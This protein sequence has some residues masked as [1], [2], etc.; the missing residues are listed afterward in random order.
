MVGTF[1]A[2][3]LK[4]GLIIRVI[5]VDFQRGKAHDLRGESL[6][7]AL[8]ADI[9][10]NLIDYVFLSPPCS[11]WSRSLY[12]QDGERALALEIEDA[13]MGLPMA[14]WKNE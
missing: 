7:G 8:L 3:G 1:R 5:E 10:G 9:Q 13:S 14:Q 11:T 2:L 4:K 12:L 6:Q